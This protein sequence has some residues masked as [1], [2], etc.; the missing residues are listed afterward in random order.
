MNKKFF[1]VMLVAVLTAS[2]AQAQFHVGMR[3]GFNAASM[4]GDFVPVFWE[5]AKVEARAGFQGGLV[6]ELE[7]GRHFAVQPGI[8]YAQQGYVASVKN[9]DAVRE[10]DYLLNYLQV[11]LNLLA[12]MTIGRSG[13]IF[14]QVGPY[15]GY[16]L[17][18]KLKLEAR[19]DGKVVETQDGIV[20]FKDHDGDTMKRLDYG[21]GFGLGFQARAVQ[22]DIEYRMGLQSLSNTSGVDMKN[23][24]IAIK[25]SYFIGK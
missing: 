18:G 7:L 14:F 16:A 19:E 10:A 6:G 23:N 13:N 9:G 20:H 5:D 12:K 17:S 4:Y 15:V 21:L 1:T 2:Y 3:L 25:L 22:F 24:G 11:P 8:L